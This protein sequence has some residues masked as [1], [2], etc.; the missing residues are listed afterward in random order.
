[1]FI[2]S[3]LCALTFLT[4][5]LDTF[6]VGFNLLCFKAKVMGFI[7]VDSSWGRGVG[8]GFKID[9][10]QLFLTRFLKIFFFSV[11]YS[12]ANVTCLTRDVHI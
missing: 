2:C 1:M 12:S 9:I 8:A 3:F 4:K 10:V 5:C 7:S 6:R 11:I